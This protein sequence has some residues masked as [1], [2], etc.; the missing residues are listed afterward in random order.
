M[1]DTAPAPHLVL[2]TAQLTQPYGVLVTGADAG[3]RSAQMLAVAASL[4]IHHLDTAPAYGE[5]E[6]AIGEASW[7]GSVHTKIAHGAE[8]SASLAS[9]LQALRRACVDVLYLHDANELT[10]GTSTVLKTAAELVGA[11]ATALGASIYD[12]T[13]LDAALARPSVRVLQVPF[14]PFDRRFAQGA[15]PR[16]SVNGIHVYAR[17]VFLQGVL[18]ADPSQLPRGVAAL[19]EPVARFQ[20]IANE[21]DVPPAALALAWVRTRMRLTGVLVG[22]QNPRELTELAAAWRANV[23]DDALAAVDAMPQPALNL[24]DPRRWEHPQ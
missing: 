13:Q 1:P 3:F 15:L 5:A 21:H 2:G 24:V 10:R 11:G 9:S 19:A 17:S 4:G 14:N 8:P 18:L 12:L 16:A 7:R 23:P 6:R 22:A 20:G